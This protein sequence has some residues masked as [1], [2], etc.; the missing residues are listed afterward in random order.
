MI[1]SSLK[2]LVITLFLKEVNSFEYLDVE[3]GAG[4]GMF[5]LN[6]VAKNANRALISIEKTSTKFKKFFNAY[7]NKKY[8][9]LFP[10][11]DNAI[12]WCAHH[13]RS[14]QVDRFFFSTLIQIQ[15]K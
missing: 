8:S 7:E 4:T 12:S 13:L 14:E 3:V 6:Y 5:A 15:K 10:F 11:Q 9:N 2:S 1:S